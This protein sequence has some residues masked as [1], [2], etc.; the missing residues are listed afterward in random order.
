[1]GPKAVGHIDADCF[2]VAAE[3]VRDEALQM[4][5]DAYH[6]RGKNATFRR[7][8][9]M[10]TSIFEQIVPLLERTPDANKFMN[11]IIRV[12]RDAAE[13]HNIVLH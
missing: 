8:M 12:V 9:L 6:L 13:R 5:R 10:R 2:Y 11:D 7:A 1:M 4:W 3:R